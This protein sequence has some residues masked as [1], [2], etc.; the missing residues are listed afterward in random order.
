M[1]KCTF[2]KNERLKSTK[3]IEQLFRKGN[4]FAKYPL[5]LVWLEQENKVDAPVQITFSVPK[6]K[7]KKAVDRNRIKRQIREAWRLNKHEL[8][9]QI[10]SKSYAFMLIYTAKEPF[11][12]ADIEK[13]MK[14]IIHKFVKVSANG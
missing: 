8:L 11:I 4:S 3:T 9:E 5:R 1:R 7:F 13:S 14:K 6:K 2:S 10:P 12:Y